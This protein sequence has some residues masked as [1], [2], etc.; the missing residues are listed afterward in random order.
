MHNDELLNKH[1]ISDIGRYLQT[2]LHKDWDDMVATIKDSEEWTEAIELAK[3][4]EAYKKVE[5]EVN[6]KVEASN[7]INKLLDQILAPAKTLGHN[8][9]SE[10]I[11]VS[12]GSVYGSH[13]RINAYT[14]ADA[15]SKLE[16][17][18]KKLAEDL[19]GIDDTDTRKE[20]ISQE[21]KARLSLMSIATFDEIKDIILNEME[22]EDFKF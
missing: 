5:V 21:L 9:T 8:Y 18:A 11:A 16:K 14:Q 15:D 17:V 13:M 7:K 20:L 4:T 19:L 12:T 2:I 1:R 6:E 3:D 22:P 10:S